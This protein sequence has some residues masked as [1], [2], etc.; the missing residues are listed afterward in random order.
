MLTLLA[1]LAACLQQGFV[2]E[3]APPAGAPPSPSLLL[4]RSSPSL[5]CGAVSS[6][7]CS[8][9]SPCRGAAAPPPPGCP[10][11]SACGRSKVIG[12]SC[13]STR[14]WPRWAD[15][16][17]AA[18]RFS[19]EGGLRLL[20]LHTTCAVINVPSLSLHWLLLLPLYPPSRRGSVATATA[21][22]PG[23]R[24]SLQAERDWLPGLTQA[25][26]TVTSR[27]GPQAFG[28]PPSIRQRIC[29]TFDATATGWQRLARTL[30]LERCVR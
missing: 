2:W 18:L 19:S 23:L 3:V 10:A 6:S 21:A 14:P 29:A 27:S 30:G 13:R 25:D 16:G 1:R 28:I 11:E 5:R 20:H 9:P 24:L 17:A 7:L 12:R 8:V 26:C 4:L 22:H 15:P